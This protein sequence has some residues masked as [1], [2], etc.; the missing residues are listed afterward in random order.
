MSRWA[1]EQLSPAMRQQAQAK[2]ALQTRGVTTHR[3]DGRG[4]LQLPKPTKYR[5]Q[6]CVYDGQK[7]DSLKEAN[8]WRDLRLLE[9]VGEIKELRRQVV[10]HLVVNGHDVCAYITDFVYIKDGRTVVEDVKGYRKGIAYRL[11]KIKA[12]LMWALHR[13]KVVEP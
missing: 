9:Y 10:Y 8:R 13:L 5:N 4:E 3:I 7:F 12:T 1:L 11:F 2:L 6:P